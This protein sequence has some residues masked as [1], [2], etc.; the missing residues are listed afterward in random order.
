MKHNNYLYLDLTRKLQPEKIDL[1]N[2]A[3]FEE[4]SKMRTKCIK[5]TKSG[6]TFGK[7]SNDVIY[8]AFDSDVNW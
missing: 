4:S 6:S 3:I 5:I 2:A 1:R 7:L 8:I